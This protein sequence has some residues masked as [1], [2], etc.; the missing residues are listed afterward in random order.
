MAAM[1]SRPHRVELDADAL[2]CLFRRQQ[3][4]MHLAT[5]TRCQCKQDSQQFGSQSPRELR[6]R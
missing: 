6:E 5:H 3:F 2:I 1:E 4:L